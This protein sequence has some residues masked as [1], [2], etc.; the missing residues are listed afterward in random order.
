MPFTITLS[1]I[2]I[3]LDSISDDSEEIITINEGKTFKNDL[4]VICLEGIPNVLF[5]SCGHICICEEC[6]KTNKFKKCPICK[7]ETNILR[8]M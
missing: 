1:L 2:R 5:C 3:D 6:S 4:C 8:I 7:N